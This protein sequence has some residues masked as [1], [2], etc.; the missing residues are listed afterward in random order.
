MSDEN[1]KEETKIDTIESVQEERKPV[2]QPS[3][4][5]QSIKPFKV[6]PVKAQTERKRQKR[7]LELE[8]R[9]VS[10]KKKKQQEEQTGTALTETPTDNGWMSGVMAIGAGICGFLLL[11]NKM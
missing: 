8:K 3:V 6:V 11:K 5:E 10:Y 2:E 9:R 7:F 1:P 4:A